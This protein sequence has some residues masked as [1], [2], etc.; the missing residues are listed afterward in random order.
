MTVGK[1]FRRVDLDHGDVCFRID[2]DDSAAIFLTRLQTDGDSRGV[3]DD[4]IVRQNVALGIDDETAADAARR[5]SLLPAKHV[6]QG[7]V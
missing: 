5:S 2:A 6:E 1:I 4:V 7:I 3:F